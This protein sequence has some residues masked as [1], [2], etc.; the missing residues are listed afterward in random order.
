[1]SLTASEL[2]K[3]SAVKHMQTSDMT[4]DPIEVCMHHA[5]TVGRCKRRKRD[6]S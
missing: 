2:R 3:Q 4:P 5:P 1:M 6:I